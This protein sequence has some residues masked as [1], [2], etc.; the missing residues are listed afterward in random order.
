MRRVDAIVKTNSGFDVIQTGG[1]GNPPITNSGC[2]K[3]YFLKE[4]ISFTNSP[5]IGDPPYCKVMPDMCINISDFIKDFDNL[6][7]I[8]VR[9]NMFAAWVDNVEY[10]RFYGWYFANSQ[11]I[12]I[13][14]GGRNVF[15]NAQN[16]KFHLVHSNTYSGDDFIHPAIQFGMQIESHIR[17]SIDTVKWMLDT[18]NIWLV[19]TFFAPLGA[20]WTRTVA[21]KDLC[22][23]KVDVFNLPP[24]PPPLVLVN[25]VP[26]NNTQ[27]FAGNEVVFEF[28]QDIM[29]AN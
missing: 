1:G 28:D 13:A 23:M 21:I 3:I 20:G 4:D 14:L 16:N 25:T 22:S 9:A 18:G 5:E 17:L 27:N 24:P 12:S 11:N 29:I 10:A 15:V 6:N 26:A 8:I 7:E 19:P 2:C